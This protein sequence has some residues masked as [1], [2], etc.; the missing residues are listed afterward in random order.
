M[1]LEILFFVILCSSFIGMIIGGIGN[2]FREEWGIVVFVI[3]LVIFVMCLILIWL[4]FI[5]GLQLFL[6][7]KIPILC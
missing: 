6:C 5:L 2:Y 4:A 1:I 3:S 7:Q